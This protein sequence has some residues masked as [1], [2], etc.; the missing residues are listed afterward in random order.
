MVPGPD[1]EPDELTIVCEDGYPLSAQLFRA[2]APAERVLTLSPATGVPARFYRR[3]CAYMASEGFT[4]LTWDWRGV[5]DSAPEEL[6][7]FDANMLDWAHLDQRAALDWAFGE[8]GQP[9]TAVGHSYGGQVFGLYPQR[10]R[11]RQLV[12]F[13][14]G[15]AYWRLWPF[16][17]RYLFRAAIAVLG[18]LARTVGYLPGEVLRLGANLPTGVARQWFHWCTLPDYHGDWQGAADLDAPVLSYGFSDDRYAPEAQRRWLLERYGGPGTFVT[19]GPADYGL[20]KIGH[21]DFF[22]PMHA[23][24]LWPDLLRRLD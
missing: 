4:T 10:S 8:F 7:D 6:R 19:I 13:A 9:L 16:P 1:I 17:D 2:K 5:G 24:R 18:Q 21:L 14:S 15:N 3:W 20:K 11:F 22:R 12:L 23:D